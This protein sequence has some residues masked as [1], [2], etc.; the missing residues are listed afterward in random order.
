MSVAVGKVGKFKRFNKRGYK[1]KGRVATRGYV[2]KMIHRNIE[3]KKVVANMPA[4]F[5]AIGNAWVEVPFGDVAQG[6]TNNTR[7]GRHISIRAIQIKLV[8]YAPDTYNTIRL[9]VALFDG[10]GGTP[11]ATAAAT[12]NSLITT[13]SGSQAKCI[14]KYLDQYIPMTPATSDALRVVDYYK[15]FKKSIQVTYGDDT[16]TYPDKRLFISMISDSIAAPH[17]TVAAGYA[18]CTYEDA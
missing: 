5:P 3:N 12:I 14:K 10:S 2:A 1:K 4:T 15:K 13:D 11:L 16:I 18:V 8:L 7:I 17:P 6:I 9:I